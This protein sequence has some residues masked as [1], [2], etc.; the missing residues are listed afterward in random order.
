MRQAPTHKAVIRPATAKPRWSGIIWSGAHAELLK[1]VETAGIPTVPTPLA[2]GCIP[3][4]HPFSCFISR[5]RAVAQS[6]VILFMGARLNFILSYGRPP[7]FNPQARTIQVDRVPEEQEP[8]RC[9]SKIVDVVSMGWRTSNV[10]GCQSDCQH[11]PKT[12]AGPVIPTAPPPPPSCR[13]PGSRQPPPAT[14]G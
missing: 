9:S 11:M 14:P 2:R 10:A 12:L 3:D 5:S 8:C 13:W 7:R 4:D 1:F 6:D